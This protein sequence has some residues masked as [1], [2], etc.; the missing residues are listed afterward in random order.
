V[1]PWDLLAQVRA[2]AESAPDRPA[3]RDARVQLSYRDFLQQ[4]ERVARGLAALG[5]APG[6]RV[7]VLVENSAEHIIVTY[8]CLS[9]GIVFVPLAVRDP[10]ERTI[11]IVRDAD[12]GLLVAEAAVAES[13]KA[14]QVV[15]AATTTEIL[16]EGET[17]PAAEVGTA[18]GADVV[19]CVYT[20]G[21][22]GQPKGVM[23][24]R[25]SLNNL[26]Q[27]TIGTFGL[28]EGTRALCVS[29]FHFDGAFGSVFSVLAAGGSLAVA[30]GSPPLPGDFF[31][32]VVRE[33]IT[34]T[35]FSPSYLRLLLAS[36][37][38][39]LLGSSSLRTLG[40]G[41]EDCS[42]AEIR[43]L[44][45]VLPAIRVFN[46]YGPTETTVVVAT[47]EVTDEILESGSKIP[48]GKPHDGVSFHLVGPGR[49]VVEGARTPGELCI[50]GIQVMAGYWAAP[51]LTGEVVRADIVAGERL[52][53]SGDLVERDEN[54]NYVYLDRLDN[55][56]KRD[57]NRIALSE[58]VKALRDIPGVDDAVCSTQVQEGRSLISAYVQA[59]GAWDAHRLRTELLRKVPRYM[60]PDQL[61]VVEDLPRNAAG[62]VSAPRRQRAPAPT[63]KERILQAS[64][65]RDLSVRRPARAML[66]IARQWLVIALVILA[67]LW[68]DT[69][70]AYL[71][72]V[73][74]IATRQHALAVLMH[75]GAHGLLLRNRARGD[76]VSDLFLAFPLFVSTT[77]YRRHHLDHHRYL[78]TDLDPDRDVPALDRSMRGWV[79]VFI[80]D[81]SGVNI[82]STVDTLDQ[83]SL[84]PVLR[85]NRQVAARMGRRSLILFMVFLAAGLV[86]VV[87]T[88]S[89]LDF[90]LFWLLPMLT[91]LSFILRLR[92][93]AE[94]VGCRQTGE[95]EGTRTVLANTVE[96]W[97]FSPCRIN[98]HLAHHLYPSV[99]FYNL[100]K[101]HKILMRNADVRR[102]AEIADSYLFGRNCV[103]AQVNA[104]Y[105]RRQLEKVG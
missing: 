52:Y 19:Y 10:L 39:S 64:D 5:L 68:L 37:D 46:R 91:T 21:S 79:K 94:H 70:W 80:G 36:R 13:V 81:L 32:T 82:L 96:R 26:V 88:S 7:G 11:Q 28:G 4:V 8:A 89:Y 85:G 105:H 98:Y 104:G 25:E 2:N 31:R 40:L 78:N 44:R 17:G 49:L 74:V 20:S 100:P 15:R 92:A 16:I 102:R 59:S 55:V 63:A 71:P 60:N 77:L 65:L 53:C 50:G 54:G 3:V 84:L 43:R 73:V 66:A 1:A 33:K 24:R 51:E 22:T 41:G 35:S 42:A 47:C 45:E 38:L 58:I 62:K 12:L 101:L 76:I 61:F 103:L 97:L 69:W 67:T 86:L 72:A 9:S 27:A 14:R 30:P 29:P 75:D 83:F 6:A 57:G 93:V 23:I 18:G 90:A 56:V 87:L 34:H 95:L 48:I 99:P